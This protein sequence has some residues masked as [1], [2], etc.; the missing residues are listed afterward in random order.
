MVQ[1]GLGLARFDSV[2]VW[3][4]GLVW[5]RTLGGLNGLNGFVSFG[6]VASGEGFI[7]GSICLFW[8]SDI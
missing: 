1:I 2:E 6:F 7:Y 5:N 3:R 8:I 4:K